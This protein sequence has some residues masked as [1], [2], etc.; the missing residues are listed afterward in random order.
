MVG[1]CVLAFLIL[2]DISGLVQEAKLHFQTVQEEVIAWLL[3]NK[4]KI[5]Q[6]V[7]TAIEDYQV[8]VSYHFVPLIITYRNS[9]FG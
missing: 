5:F 1:C 9:R 6:A 4:S 7:K 8:S 3:S 2:L